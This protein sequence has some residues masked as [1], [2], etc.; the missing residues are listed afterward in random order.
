MT[1]LAGLSTRPKRPRVSTPR[2]SS[3]L[4]PH[5]VGVSGPARPVQ[6]QPNLAEGRKK[7]ALSLSFLSPAHPSV[8][9]IAS[10]ARGGLSLSFRGPGCGSFK[11]R[12][13]TVKLP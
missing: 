12:D 7:F 5:E 11:H 3:T 1:L 2:R 6:W 4:P 10:L 8:M 13:T 9:S